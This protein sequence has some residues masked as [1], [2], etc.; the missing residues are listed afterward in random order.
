L[1]D[2]NGRAVLS[3]R[4]RGGIVALA[5]FNDNLIRVP[6]VPW[7]P[8]AI[9]QKLYESRQSR[10]FDGEELALV[11]GGLGIYSD[12]QSLN[13]EDAITWSYFGPVSAADS[14]QRAS[15]LNWLIGRLGLPWTDSTGCSVDLWRRIPHPDKSLP[16]GPELD[17]VL[18]GDR[19]VVFVE[20][21]WGS[22]EGR[23]QGVAKDKTQLQLRREFLA[24]HGPRIYGPARAFVVLAVVLAGELEQ[25]PPADAG[26]VSTR[27][28]TWA[29][30]SE[31]PVHPCREEFEAYYRWK[32][33]WSRAGQAL[34]HHSQ[35]R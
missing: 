10:A 35:P 3:A 31:C 33:Q 22:G 5:D 20:A 25:Q 13:S 19:C 12:L 15:V 4:S 21:K 11:T 18:D 17:V 23:R 14:Q 29:N 1:I 27:T 26:G 6:G 30:L 8:P 34:T 2:W 28:I 24:K 32:V 7:P 16:G 9:V